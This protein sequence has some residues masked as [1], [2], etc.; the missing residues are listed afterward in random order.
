M[1]NARKGF[2][3]VEITLHTDASVFDSYRKEWS[4]LLRHSAANDIFLTC[5]WQGT[6]WQV[7]HPGRLRVL[8]VQ[9]DDG[10]WVG[11]APWFVRTEGDR[12]IV[13]TV[14]CA[15]V[16][17]YLDIVAWQ[18]WEDA[19]YEA[20]L[21]WLAA[22]RSD[23]DEVH[24]CNIPQNSPALSRVPALAP[25]HHLH[26]E[27]HVEDVCPT[28]RLPRRF[29][30]YL[31]ALDKKKRHELRR[32]LRRAA[33]VA[34]WYLVEVGEHDLEAELER[35]LVLMAA[36]SPEKAAF[37]AVP[38][39]RAFFQQIVPKMANQGWL[40][41]AFLTVEGEAAAAYLNFTYRRRVLVYN[42]GIRP[43]AHGYLSPGIVLL[44]WLIRYA[45]EQEYA[46][47]DFLRGDEPYKYDLG[48]RDTY[49]YRLLISPHEKRIRP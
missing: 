21:G 6:W 24:L 40:Q 3:I 49:I 18:G 26:A 36:S 10:R 31:A 42:S 13:Q 25:P 44:G 20:L 39:N 35:F 38:E 16:T 1:P 7:Y 11:L 47:F 8:V 12:R 32:K 41:L 33:G 22:H 2:G 37:L 4:E 45:I 17:D 30:D 5:C 29:E 19:V 28:V 15:D 43:D 48:G 27:A 14:G 9:D 34:D 46:E 23:Y